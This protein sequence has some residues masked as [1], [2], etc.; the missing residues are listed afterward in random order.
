MNFT[1]LSAFR[2][3]WNL[4]FRPHVSLSARVEYL[5]LGVGIAKSHP[6]STLSAEKQEAD[7]YLLSEIEDLLE[8]AHIQVEL[9]NMLSN[10]LNEKSNDV[11]QKILYLHSGLLSVTEVSLVKMIR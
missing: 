3:S 9:Q 4:F 1:Y 5:T 8:V 11:Q 6:F 2:F 10:Q 7:L